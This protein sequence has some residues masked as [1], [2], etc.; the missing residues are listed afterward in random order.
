M[1]TGRLQTGGLGGEVVVQF[2]VSAGG[3]LSGLR[4]ARSSGDA[5]VDETGLAMVN[6]AAPFSPIPP[7]TGQSSMNFSLPIYFEH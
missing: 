7:E 1:F 3:Q 2:T 6:R 4:I 5:A